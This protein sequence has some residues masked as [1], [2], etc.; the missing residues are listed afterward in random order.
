MKLKESY[1]FTPMG[2]ESVL[3]PT[4]EEAKFFHGIANCNSSAADLIKLLM[5]ETSEDEIVAALA[6]KYPTSEAKLRIGVQKSLAVLRS[7]QAL[8]E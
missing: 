4:G 7:I 5:Q 3:V 1:V 2:E 6:V 8:D